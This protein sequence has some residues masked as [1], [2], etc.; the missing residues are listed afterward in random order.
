MNKLSLVD[1]QADIVR[2]SNQFQI[3]DNKLLFEENQFYRILGSDRKWRI[4]QFVGDTFV[5]PNSIKAVMAE[6]KPI[7]LVPKFEKLDES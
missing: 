3:F 2:K 1:I 4:A 6:I 5:L 7:S